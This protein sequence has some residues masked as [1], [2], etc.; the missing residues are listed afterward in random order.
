MGKVEI[1]KC[2]KVQYKDQNI[3][4]QQIQSFSLILEFLNLH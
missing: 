3:D 2:N 1:N 4:S